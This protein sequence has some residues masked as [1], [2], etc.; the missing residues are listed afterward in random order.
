[1]NDYK[2]ETGHRQFKTD[3]RAMRFGVGFDDRDSTALPGANARVDR[4]AYR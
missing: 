2:F 4:T 3:A 1:M